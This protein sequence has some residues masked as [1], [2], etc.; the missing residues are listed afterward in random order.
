MARQALCIGINDYPGTA[1]DLAGCVN[2]A[3]DWAAELQQRGFT[4]HTLL[5][6]QATKAAM[7][8]A[9]R[10]RLQAAAPGDLVV[11]TFSG[12]G[13]IAPDRDGDE[14]DGYDEALCPFDIGGG[15]VLIDDD[16]R[17]LFTSRGPG[18]RLVLISDSCHSGTLLRQPATVA[19][20]LPRPRF[21]PMGSWLP[22]AALPRGGDQQPLASLPITATRSPWTGAV[23]GGGDLLMAGCEE[24]PER[25]SY[26]GRFA[27][28]ANG[29][30]SHYALRTLRSL[31]ADATYA[32][33]YAAIRRYLPAAAYQQ[34]PQLMGSQ[35]VLASPVLQ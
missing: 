32:Q 15:E 8:Q 17:G 6:D 23:A 18:V 34:T 5:D 27:G 31:P 14:A 29:A 12:H 26:D 3:N 20:D 11:I 1:S 24:G 21:L 33:W 25:F 10:E 22:E 13:T 9:I 30:F 7:V 28:R 35:E 2:D 19:A 4:V 16:I